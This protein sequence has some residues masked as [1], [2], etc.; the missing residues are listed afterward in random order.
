MPSNNTSNANFWNKLYINKDTG[1]DIGYATP[2]FVSWSKTLQS[3]SK[4]LIP[5]CGNCYDGIY[6]SKLNH[7]VYAV[8]FSEKVIDNVLQK[9]KQ[10][11]VAINAICKD[12]FLLDDSYYGMFDIVLEYTFFCAIPINMRQLYIE[13]TYNMLKTGGKLISIFLPITKDEKK[14]GPPFYVDLDKTIKSFEKYFTIESID[15]NPDSVKPRIGNE[16]F[17]KMLKK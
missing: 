1:W 10:E 11:D 14:E 8:D 12:Y 7:D 17:V 9:S 6:L 2:I 3:K 4:I 15:M 16:V 5:G 13:T